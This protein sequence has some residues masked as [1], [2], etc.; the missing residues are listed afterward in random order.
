MDVAHYVYSPLKRAE[1]VMIAYNT[2]IPSDK[3]KMTIDEAVEVI[4]R[5]TPLVKCL[6]EMKKS[7]ITSIISING[8]DF[9]C[10]IRPWESDISRLNH[11]DEIIQAL[12]EG[13]RKNYPGYAFLEDTGI[14]EQIRE[15]GKVR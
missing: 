11:I 2:I 14:S 1:L 9:R 10:D 7:E 13:K 8:I 6:G 3:P 5:H 15:L 4:D 12:E